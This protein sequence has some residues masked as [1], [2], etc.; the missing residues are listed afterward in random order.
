MNRILLLTSL[1]LGTFAF[2]GDVSACRDF[3]ETQASAQSS[4]MVATAPAAS[5]A[6]V[7]ADAKKTPVTVGKSAS[8]KAAKRPTQVAC[9]GANCDAARDVR[10]EP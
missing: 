4:T 8:A 2:A 6:P 5:K 1:A 7:T 10:V 3:D 9:A